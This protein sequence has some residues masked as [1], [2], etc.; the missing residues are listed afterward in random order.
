MIG[1]RGRPAAGRSLRPVTAPDLPDTMGD[2]AVAYAVL[3]GCTTAARLAHEWSLPIA[4]A[5]ALLHG[6]AERRHLVPCMDGGWLAV[7]PDAMAA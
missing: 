6:A 4:H 1:R 7:D 2:R 5:R 3:C